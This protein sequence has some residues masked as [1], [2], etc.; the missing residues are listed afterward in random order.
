MYDKLAGMT[1]TAE[2]EAG[3]FHDIYKL[4]VS[5]IPT[6]EK[7][8]RDDMEDEIYRTRREKYNAIIREIQEMQRLGRPCLVGTISV[9][10]H[11]Y[12]LFFSVWFQHQ[13]IRHHQLPKA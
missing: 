4:D 9:E 7:V 5:V 13:V 3:E 8:I 11:K 1:G 6:N 2:T 10:V 12:R